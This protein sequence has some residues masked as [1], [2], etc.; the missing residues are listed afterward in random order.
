MK[1]KGIDIS[2]W[3]QG[4]DLGKAKQEGYEYCINWKW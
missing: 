3:Q 1:I 2:S 4:M